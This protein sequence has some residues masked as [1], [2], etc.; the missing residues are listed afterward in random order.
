MIHA[1]INRCLRLN[2]RVRRAMQR[3][4]QPLLR[5]IIQQRRPEREARRAA[6]GLAPAAAG[7][8]VVVRRARRRELV[9]GVGRAAG[10]LLRVLA[11]EALERGE[12]ADEQRVQ[13]DEAGADDD[14]VELDGGPEGRDG[15]VVRGVVGDGEEVEVVEADDAGYAAAGVGWVR[16]GGGDGGKGVWD[17]QAAECEGEC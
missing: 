7:R 12:H 2:R 4:G 5:R 14:D 9:G 6:A 8:A 10:A 15:V 13:G 11:G 17:L 16:W 1:Q 3:P